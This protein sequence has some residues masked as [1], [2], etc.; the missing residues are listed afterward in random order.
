MFVSRATA[1]LGVASVALACALTDPF[2]RA[3]SAKTPTADFHQQRSRRLSHD[4]AS[5]TRWNTSWDDRD[6][7][8]DVTRIIWLVRHGQATEE[9]RGEDDGTRRLTNLGRAQ[10]EATARRL[11]ELLRGRRVHKMTHSTMARAEETANIIARFAFPSVRRESSH[12]LR[13]GA[14]P[15]PEPDT[16]RQSEETHAEDAPRLESAF[17][18]V[19]HR[20]STSEDRDRASASEE[21]DRE[22]HD[23]VVCH[24]NV[25]RYF[26]L[27][28][29]QLPPDAWLRLGLYN[30]SVTRVEIR[31]DGGVS[32]RCLGDAGHL[33]PDQL[34]HN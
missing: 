11:G 27:R 30:A 17:R 4:A 28:A 19:F 26:V 1:S 10:A 24:A 20:A 7:T 16:W 33:S 9:K 34:T 2:A 18:S 5:R 6:E 14:P 13:E 12:L 22:R 25:I 3:E 23:I 8:T 31:P 29:L 15:R 21:R 32:V